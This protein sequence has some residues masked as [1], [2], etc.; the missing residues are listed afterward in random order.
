M[1][2]AFF[3]LGQEFTRLQ[4][5]CAKQ[6]ELL[7]K[8]IPGKDPLIDLPTSMPIQCT[9]DTVGE[10]VER[11]N[12]RQPGTKPSSAITVCPAAPR[13]RDSAVLQN[14][15]QAVDV[16]SALAVKYPPCAENDR[17]LSSGNGKLDFARA[18]C[19]QPCDTP[20]MGNMA[21]FDAQLN[22]DMAFPAF[23]I[24]KRDSLAS[25]AP[26]DFALQN[27]VCVDSLFHSLDL[28][29]DPQ[30]A[31]TEYA[32]RHSALP[33]EMKVPVEIRGPVKTSW[34]PGWMLE[35]GPL[36]ESGPPDPEATEHMQTCDFSQALF[37]AATAQGD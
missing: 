15:P 29:E 5:L 6:S 33:T 18:L 22:D 19:S 3:Q 36:G 28:Y 27:P 9:D 23:N 25:S 1:E 8:L 21:N 14:Q 34:T 37:P 35:D 16:L 26:Q 17:L 20:D 7:Q 4:H 24:N 10:E 30:E 11:P 13:L 12:F 31:P 32:P 2:E